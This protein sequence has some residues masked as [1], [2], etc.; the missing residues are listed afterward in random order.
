MGAIAQGHVV[1]G[2]DTDTFFSL[3]WS[4][5]HSKTETTLKLGNVDNVGRF[6]KHFFKNMSS[7]I[8]EG[9]IDFLD[10]SSLR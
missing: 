7:T 1:K 3:L 9:T 2:E 4:K 8:L 6:E 10:K 5:K